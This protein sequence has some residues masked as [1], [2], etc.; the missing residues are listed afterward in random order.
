[1]N[2]YELC[3]LLNVA[4]E[5]TIFETEDYKLQGILLKNTT[6]DSANSL[7]ILAHGRQDQVMPLS[8]TLISSQIAFATPLGSQLFRPENKLNDQQSIDKESTWIKHKAQKSQLLQSSDDSQLI[9]N[10]YIGTHI[11]NELIT[12]I[13]PM[14]DALNN[15]HDIFIPTELIFKQTLI[16]EFNENKMQKTDSDGKPKFIT[17]KHGQRPIMKPGIYASNGEFNCR[18]QQYNDRKIPLADILSLLPTYQHILMCTCR[19]PWRPKSN[20][21]STSYENSKNKTHPASY[22]EFDCI[23]SS[24]GILLN[25]PTEA[26]DPII[27]DYLFMVEKQGQTSIDYNI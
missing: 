27:P 13:K 19:S 22:K 25:P 8:D 6:T 20:E 12:S 9:P 2:W 21:L 11:P 16:S 3:E 23:Y 24:D 1:M 10:L 7:V 14:Q 18:M 15:G 17:T 5:T 26:I 4:P